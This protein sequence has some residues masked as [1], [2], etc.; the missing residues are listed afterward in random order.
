MIT[1]HDELMRYRGNFKSN[2]KIRK[3]PD[4]E[5][6]TVKKEDIE[7]DISLSN[8]GTED[9]PG[10]ITGKIGCAVGVKALRYC[11]KSLLDDNTD[12]HFTGRLMKLVKGIYHMD[13]EGATGKKSIFF[14]K[15][16][17]YLATMVFHIRERNVEMLFNQFKCS[18]TTF[19]DKATLSLNELRISHSVIPNGATHYRIL[20]H[21]SIISDYTYSEINLTFEPLSLLNTLNAMAYSKYIPVGVSLTDEIVVSLAVNDDMP[22]NVSVIQCVG[23]AYYIKSGLENFIIIRGGSVAVYDVF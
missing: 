14:S 22:D 19:R 10:I 5:T 3:R 4:E 20:N 23:I 11:F 9:Y 7:S 18:H 6:K 17:E 2:H 13:R 15:E 16:R 1:I 8:P 12:S 21:L